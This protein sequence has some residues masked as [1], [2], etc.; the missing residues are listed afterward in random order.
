MQTARLVFGFL[1][2][3]VAGAIMILYSRNLVSTVIRS[4]V[5]G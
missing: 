1:Q 4:F 5:V 3:A 2:A